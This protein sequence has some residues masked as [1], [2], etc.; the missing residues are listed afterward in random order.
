M[1][2]VFVIPAFRDNYIWV[3]HDADRRHA[4]VVDPGDAAPVERVLARERL[5]LAG[6][7]TTHHHADHVG[8]VA[9]LLATRPDIPVWGPAGES[10]PG[11]TVALAEGDETHLVVPQLTFR[12]LDIPGHTA[13]HIA[14]FGDGMLFCGDTLFAGGCGRLFEGTAAQ[15]LRSLE[16]LAALPGE[17]RVYCAH[18][19]TEANL[20]FVAQ[21]EPKNEKLQQRYQAVRAQRRDGSITLPSNLALERATNPFLRCDEQGVITS[22]RAHAGRD[23]PDRESVFTA[24]RVWKDNF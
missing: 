21:V 22:A 8:G 16:H 15:M 18:E 7:F 19:Y 20:R 11:R 6:I 9:A 5:T 2:P 24:V 14:Y 13:G 12:I 10:I 1:D 17:T 4:V 3:L 23:L